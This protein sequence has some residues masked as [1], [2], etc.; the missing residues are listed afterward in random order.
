MQQGNGAS[1]ANIVN[2][3]LLVAAIGIAVVTASRSNAADIL[4]Q[5]HQVSESPRSTINDNMKMYSKC[6]RNG[7]GAA[8]SQMLPTNKLEKQNFSFKQTEQRPLKQISNC[9]NP[10]NGNQSIS[11]D[12]LKLLRKY[13]EVFFKNCFMT[14]NLCIYSKSWSDIPMLDTSTIFTLHKSSC[15]TSS[16]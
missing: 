6:Y 10:K 11:K 2:H 9:N 7:I 15:L 3:L 12:E 16:L 14:S 5:T 13:I 4:R 8:S 1:S